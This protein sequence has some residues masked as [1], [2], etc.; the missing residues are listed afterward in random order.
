MHMPLIFM[1][2]RREVMNGPIVSNAFRVKEHIA[3]NLFVGNC[4]QVPPKHSNAKQS[5]TILLHG[6]INWQGE[7]VNE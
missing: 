7:Q 3:L 6:K 4:T 5:I 1:D 2:Y